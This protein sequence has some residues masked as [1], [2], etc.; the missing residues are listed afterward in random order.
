MRKWVLRLFGT[1][2]TLVALALLGALH[3]NR[4]GERGTRVGSRRES[5]RQL[6]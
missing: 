4:S 3:T 1:F 2:L 6:I 5:D